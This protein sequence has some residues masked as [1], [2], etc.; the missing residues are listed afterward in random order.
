MTCGGGGETRSE[1]H[2]VPVWSFGH[3]ADTSHR[4]L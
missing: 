4:R 3:D 2:M 1:G